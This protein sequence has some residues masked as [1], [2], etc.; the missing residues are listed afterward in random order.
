VTEQIAQA[1]KVLDIEV[2]GHLIVGRLWHVS[3]K[4]RGLGVSQR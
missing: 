3:L 4:G 1:G 2:L